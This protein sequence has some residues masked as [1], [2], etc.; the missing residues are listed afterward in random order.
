MIMGKY[1]L[2]DFKR[3]MGSKW[4]RIYLL[5]GLVLILLA[6]IAVI[7]FRFIYGTCKMKPNVFAESIYQSLPTLSI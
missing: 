4:T 2:N 7:C 1:I 6:N 3:A 5:A